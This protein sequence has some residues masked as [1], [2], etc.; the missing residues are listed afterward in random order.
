MCHVAEGPLTYQLLG[1]PTTSAP[2]IA[3]HLVSTVYVGVTAMIDGGTLAFGCT[4]TLPNC[5]HY[6]I[7]SW[8][9]L[10]AEPDRYSPVFPGVLPAGAAGNVRGVI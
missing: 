8:D 7:Y 9:I 1:A 5:P 4:V 3:M 10:T 2:P 6:V